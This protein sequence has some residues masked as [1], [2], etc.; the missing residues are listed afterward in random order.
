MPSPKI[1]SAGV[2]AA[3][4]GGQEQGQGHQVHGHGPNDAAAALMP[5]PPASKAPNTAHASPKA[6]PEAGGGSTNHHLNLRV[7]AVTQYQSLLWNPD[8]FAMISLDTHG[9]CPIL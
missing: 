1:L 2:G 5:S 7:K 8:G 3:G 6:R 4:G 9:V